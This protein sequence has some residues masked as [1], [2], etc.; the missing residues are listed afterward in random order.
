MI[1][2]TNNFSLEWHASMNCAQ[3]EEIVFILISSI[4][5]SNLPLSNY[6]SGT[7]IHTLS[8]LN[9]MTVNNSKKHLTPIRSLSC[10][11]DLTSE[12]FDPGSVFH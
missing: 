5:H 12:I 7:E 8:T 4:F 2:K 1:V 11:A 3:Y 10:P 6:K 9:Q